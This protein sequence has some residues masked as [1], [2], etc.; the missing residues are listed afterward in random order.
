MNRA[1]PI[2]ARPVTIDVCNMTINFY[3]QIA[4]EMR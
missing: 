3:N 4:D 1:T 2:A